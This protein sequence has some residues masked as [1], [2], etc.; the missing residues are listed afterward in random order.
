LPRT[1]KSNLIEED[2]DKERKKN[3]LPPL[4]SKKPNYEHSQLKKSVKPECVDSTVPTKV[5]SVTPEC[6]DS[7]TYPSASIEEIPDEE[8]TIP[9]EMAP[10]FDTKEDIW[11]NYEPMVTNITTYQIQDEDILIEYLA[12]GTEMRL[13]KN[14]SFDSPLTKGGTSKNEMKFSNKAQQFTIAGA[15]SEVEQNKKSFKELVPGYLH[16]FCDIFAKDGLNRLPPEQPGIDHHIETKPG[17]ILKTSKIYPLS[18]KEQS[19]VKA[20]IDENKKKGFI[21]ESK[22]PQASGFFFVGMKSGELCPC[23]DYRYINDWMIKNSYLL[24]LPL[25]LITRLHDAKYFT[26]MDVRSGVMHKL[27]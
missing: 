17:F 13:I 3:G 5:E 9:E 20:F 27:G 21:S 19:A 16:D 23:Q 10:I 18:E 24:P 11:G 14:V 4:F 1:L 12:D 22:S 26:K 25:T 8:M 6:I 15:R 7:T 2:V